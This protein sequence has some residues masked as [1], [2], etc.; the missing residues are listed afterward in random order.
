MKLSVLLAISVVLVLALFGCVQKPSQTIVNEPAPAEQNVSAA[1]VTPVSS[2]ASG[3]I[4][5]KDACFVSLAKQ[6]GDPLVCKSIYS[7]ETY[8]ECLFQFSSSLDVCKEISDSKLRTDCLTKIAVT[9]KSESICNQISNLTDRLACL[10]QVLPPCMLATEG[11]ARDLCFA[12]EKSDFTECK[13]NACFVSYALNRSSTD[14]CLLVSPELEEWICRARVAN[15]TAVCKGASQIAIQDACIESVSET[16]NDLTGCDLGT[17]GSTYRNSCYNYFAVAFSNMDICKMT[18]TEHARDDCYKNYSVQVANAT[19]C[20]KI[21]E[22]LNR[23]SCY[24]SSSFANMMPSL[25]NDLP[26]L[27]MKG[28]CYARSIFSTAGPVSYDCFSVD[29]ADWKDKCFY[30]A[31]KAENNGALCLHMSPGSEQD[32]CKRLLG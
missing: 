19:A 14:A 12:L 21:V 1:P 25:C 10:R 31:A 15:S 29:N 18:A 6:K 9:E 30:A 32:E 3:N 20:G 26:T 11:D 13:S 5:Q 23:Q 22:S 28:D 2:C 17:S 16:L 27:S 8:D 24:Y 7:I 4:L